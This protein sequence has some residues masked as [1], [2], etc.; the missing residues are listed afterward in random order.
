MRPN[1]IFIRINN[2]TQNIQK[3]FQS[4]KNI[5]PSQGLE[6]KI[7]KAISIK[8]SLEIRKKMMFVRAGLAVSFGA[9][10]Y[11]LF[12]FGKAFLESDFWNLAKLAFSDSGVIASHVGDYSVSLLET[13]PVVEIFAMLLPAFAVMIML[14]YYFKF[15]N[16]KF[17]S[18]K[19]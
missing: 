7:L 3:I 18:F 15:T 2:M 14:S 8:K 17:N 16:N 9:L 6:G 1:Y 5:E 4:L 13:L 10:A 12:V 19:L 11:T